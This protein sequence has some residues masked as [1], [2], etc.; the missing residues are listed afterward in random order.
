MIIQEKVEVVVNNNKINFYRENGFPDCKR[1]D[2]IKIPVDWLGE[3]SK[4]EI[5]C[6]CDYC[7]K[8]FYKAYGELIVGRKTIQ[9]DSCNDCK[10]KKIEEV[11]LLKYGVKTNLVLQENKE[12][13]KQTILKKYGV[14]NVMQNEKIRKKQQQALFKKYG[15]T[16]PILNPQIREKIVNTYIKK[17]GKN[18]ISV[19][20]L[21]IINGVF[22]S[23]AQKTICDYFNFEINY[24]IGPYYVDGFKDNIIIEYNGGGHDLALKQGKISEEKF[25]L[26]EKE[27]IK[28]LNK[29][30]SILIIEN[31]KDFE[32]S[33]EIL[34]N[35]EDKLKNI[36]DKEVIIYQVK[37]STTIE[38]V[39]E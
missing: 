20:G 33:K 30:Y 9:K 23:K 15:V 12:K 31:K 24:M 36:K 10:Y 16:T 39:S 34:T 28:F 38:N 21:Y 8:I 26:K 37:G 3:T 25:N 22:C 29:N 5:L 27:R 32:I 35:I 19:N 6:K 1:F 2:K 4:I 14:L 18:R 11:N 17:Y 13:T 7:G